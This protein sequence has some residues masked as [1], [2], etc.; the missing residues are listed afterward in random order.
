LKEVQAAAQDLD[1]FGKTVELVGLSPFQGT[2]DALQEINDV[3]EGIMSDFLQATL[4]TNLPKGSKKKA[5]TLGVWEKN[6]AG[7][8]KAAFPNLACE[9]GDTNPVVGDLLRGLREHGQKLIK[10]LQPGDLERSIVRR[11]NGH[12]DLG[13]ELTA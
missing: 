9:T 5:I 1:K 4:E 10:K 2:S 3:S 11:N 13:A 12:T 7:S 6:L 8:I